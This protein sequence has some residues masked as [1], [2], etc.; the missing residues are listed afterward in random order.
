MTLYTRT[1]DR[2]ETLCPINFERVPKNH[3]CVELY[4]E[5][6][7]AQAWLGLAEV[8]AARL[9]RRF[10]EVLRYLQELLFRLGFTLAGKRGCVGERDVAE[11]ERLV[12]EFWGRR[13][14]TYFTLHGG[15]AESAYIGVARAVVRRLE[16]RLVDCVSK[17]N[18]SGDV[19]EVA[20]KIVNRMSDVLYALE[21]A[22]TEASGAEPVKAPTC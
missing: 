18:C 21:V 20:L 1:G 17:L 11:L 19:V 8:H 2:G 7:E 14:L 10:A 15:T 5:L 4:G 22:A 9:G 6:D 12:D 3:P 13:R 16:R